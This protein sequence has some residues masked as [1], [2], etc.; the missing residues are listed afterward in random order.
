MF[1]PDCLS[2][3][4]VQE[5]NLIWYIENYFLPNTIE[6]LEELHFESSGSVRK[7]R[8]MLSLGVETKSSDLIK[9]DYRCCL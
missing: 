3:V 5:T 2:L 6:M 4:S 1:I 7:V 9:N 8:Q